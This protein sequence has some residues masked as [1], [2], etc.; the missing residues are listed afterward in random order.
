MAI[1]ISANFKQ[2]AIKNGTAVLQFEVLASAD[3]FM[4]L[5]KM[6]NGHVFLSVEKPQQEIPFEE[7]EQPDNYTINNY[8]IDQNGEVNEQEAE[9]EFMLEAG[10]E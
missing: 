4:D 1:E 8:F 7:P 10:E 5:V 2:I 3:G 6:G 9:P